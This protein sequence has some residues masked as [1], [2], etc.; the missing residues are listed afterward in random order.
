MLR[1][2][3]SP[4]DNDRKNGGNISQDAEKEEIDNINITVLSRKENSTVTFFRSNLG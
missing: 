4:T 2:T 3:R 1:K